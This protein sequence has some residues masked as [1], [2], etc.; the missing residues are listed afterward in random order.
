MRS[1]LRVLPN[2]VFSLNLNIGGTIEILLW[3]TLILSGCQ[4]EDKM[5]PESVP[6]VWLWDTCSMK[7]LN[8]AQTPNPDTTWSKVTLP[9][10]I[11]VV[12]QAMWYVSKI[13]SSGNHYLFI[14]ANDGAQIFYDEMPYPAI[15][16]YYYQL[17]ESND[18]C[19]LKIRVLNS[20]QQGGL[21]KVLWKQRD[22]LDFIWSEQNNLLVQLE[23]IY[24]SD[25]YR[26]D[27]FLPVDGYEVNNHKA[28]R[29]TCWGD[30]QGGWNVFQSLCNLMLNIP[31][32]DFSVGLGDLVSDGVS[33]AQWYSF[34]TCLAPLIEKQVQIY[35]L[36]GKKDY[37]GY[38]DHLIPKNYLNHFTTENQPTYTSWSAGPAIFLALDPNAA[39]PHG[40]DTVQYQWAMDKMNSD[41]WQKATWRFILCHQPPYAQGRPGYQGDGFARSFVEDFSCR[42]ISY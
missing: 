10:S 8:V 32:L 36:P 35:P 40:L 1:L 20:G 38:Y 3:T 11:S 25:L 41:R 22:S 34:L 26:S 29:F 19:W 6:D 24:F 12:D 30:S 2:K 21:K 16:G 31:R 28:I 15:R 23:E 37:N 18:S 33:S 17:P 14:D 13:K 5:Q 7:E 39:F 42:A 27:V 9:H 4:V